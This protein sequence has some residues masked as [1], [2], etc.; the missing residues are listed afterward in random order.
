MMIKNLVCA[1]SKRAVTPAIATMILITA[2]LVLSLVVGA[3]TFGFLGQSAADVTLSSAA[4]FG[5][6][7]SDNLT[8]VGT[9]YFQFFLKNPGHSSN[10]TSITLSGGAL[11]APIYSWSTTPNG[12]PHNSLTV[13]GNNLLSAGSTTQYTLFPIQNPPVGITIGQTYEYVISLS[14]GQSISGS[15]IAQ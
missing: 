2:T 4:L 9:A 8:T 10:L 15:L 6:L 13:G 3:Y 11:T 12:Q 14:N 5:G 1:K 7:T